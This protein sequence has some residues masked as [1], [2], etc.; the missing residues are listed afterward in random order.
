V[1]RGG[2][3]TP[4]LAVDQL[5]PFDARELRLQHNKRKKNCTK[6]HALV[7]NGSV[8]PRKVGKWCFCYESV[9]FCNRCEIA[10]RWASS[11]PSI[12]P[13]SAAPSPVR[14]PPALL[15]S[16]AIGSAPGEQS[17][18]RRG[19][20][21]SMITTAAPSETIRSSSAKKSIVAVPATGYESASPS[22]RS[23]YEWVN[24]IRKLITVNR[25][26]KKAA[27]IVFLA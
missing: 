12:T 24:D 9:P 5:T 17:L 11:A 2:P 20:S 13:R 14:I 18:D 25:A 3:T 10:L 23:Q 1:A 15:V 4:Q 21:Q 27:S 7:K 22:N 16:S 8:R 26:P 6:L 19:M